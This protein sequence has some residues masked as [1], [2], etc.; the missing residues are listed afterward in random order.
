MLSSRVAILPSRQGIRAQLC[1]FS[2][3]FSRRG[4]Y[5][6]VV[7]WRPPSSATFLYLF[8]IVPLEGW[9]HVLSS[10]FPSTRGLATKEKLS[11]GGLRLARAGWSCLRSSCRTPSPDDDQPTLRAASDSHPLDAVAR[12]IDGERH[13][14]LTLM[15]WKCI[16]RTPTVRVRREQ[17]E[18]DVR[19]VRKS[20]P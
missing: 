16:V 13:A 20:Q 3:R 11:D 14:L 1:A 8:C 7:R 10:L 15:G 12:P 19:W 6:P 2:C 5:G 18:R 17:K 9:N 4:F